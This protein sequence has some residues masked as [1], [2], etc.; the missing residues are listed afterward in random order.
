MSSSESIN[1]PSTM[2]HPFTLLPPEIYI[3]IAQ[4]LPWSDLQ[5]FRHLSRSFY[6]LINPYVLKFLKKA[7]LSYSEALLL[8]DFDPIMNKYSLKRFM[9]KG[10]LSAFL[11]AAG[12]KELVMLP[13]Q[14]VDRNA[15]RLVIREEEMAGTRTRNIC[16]GRTEQAAVVVTE[17][18]LR[19]TRRTFN[20]LGIIERLTSPDTVFDC[21]I[22]DSIFEEAKDLLAWF[23][24]EYPEPGPSSGFCTQDDR[25]ERYIHR[26]E[27]AQMGKLEPYEFRGETVELDLPEFRKVLLKIICLD[28]VETLEK[29]K[30]GEGME[31]RISA[32]GRA[33][34]NYELEPKEI[35]TGH[36]LS[37]T[38]RSVLTYHKWLEDNFAYYT[39]LDELNL[40]WEKREEKRRD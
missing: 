34:P 39:R 11:Q 27:R 21:A 13:E 3:L 4:H 9:S 32:F 36:R 18:V 5:T 33:D 2:P 6:A 22:S 28:M 35:V 24:K 23:Q 26:I 20:F 12:M 30:R 14:P 1:L 31:D 15:P 17:E 16:D 19:V 29:I 8:L 40:E 25:V 38:F 37:R 7:K 10:Q